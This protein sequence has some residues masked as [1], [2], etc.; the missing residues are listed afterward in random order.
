MVARE[1]SS[2]ET[3]RCWLWD[4]PPK[5]C[6]V[7]TGSDVLYVAY[8]A[9]AELGCHLALGWQ[10]P[11][12]VLDLYAEYRWMTSGRRPFADFSLLGAL[13]SFG[14]GGIPAVEKSSMRQLA[15]RGGPYSGEEQQLLLKYCESDVIALTQLLHRMLPHL[16]LALAVIRGRY[17]PAVAKVERDGIP[18]DYS[19]LNAIR[20]RWS[21]LRLGLV[22]KIDRDYGVY[23]GTT[24]KTERW[25]AWCTAAGICWPRLPGGRLDLKRDTF[26]KMGV[27]HPRVL[28][29]Y[30]LRTTLSE[31]QINKL[32]VGPDQR[33]RYLVGAFGTKTGR[34]A[35]SST[36][37]IFGPSRWIRHLIKPREG[38]ALAYL[39]WCQ[40]ELGI[41]ASLSGDQ[42]MQDVYKSDDPYLAF[43][44]L[45][46]AVPK[47]ATKGSHPRERGI[48][49]VASL[50]VL[51]GMGTEALG[52]AT[53]TSGAMGARLLGQHKEKF[54]RFWEWSDSQVD[55]AMMGETLRSNYGW[56]LHPEV[57]G[58]TTF[59]N[60]GLQANGAEMLRIAAM[61]IT[62]RGISLCALVHD[63][64]LIE[65]PLEEIDCAVVEVKTCMAAA[66]R[67]VLG[68]FE[69][70]T[71]SYV[72]RWPNRFCDERGAK[73]WK[74]VME[75]LGAND[76]YAPV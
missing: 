1:Y 12:Q 62:E 69:L 38:M 39:D 48:Y 9:S 49:K 18:I 24:F 33:N 42:V 29:I 37:S 71:E 25:A 57:D 26:R 66:S 28:P 30:E 58:P 73:M 72:V 14:L 15:I 4:S 51:M 3:I 45:A 35:P 27:I 7:P 44:S 34:N 13:Q 61:A 11:V 47:T 46:G 40:Q 60:F 68:G 52:E 74:T 6:P 76:A 55:R 65:A 17:M 64:L 70:E 54:S 5:D 36:K 59:R 43:A 22:E 21:G 19:L 50:A 8:L 16:D 63:A 20:A 2:G 23:E 31:L 53:G 67:A 75:L 41:A 56:Q 10:M 32:A